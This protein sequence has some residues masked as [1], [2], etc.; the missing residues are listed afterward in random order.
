M[1]SGSYYCSL[2]EGPDVS[3]VPSAL[4]HLFPTSPDLD[5]KGRKYVFILE[6]K[7]AAARHL[8]KWK[9]LASG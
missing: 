5:S 6:E 2:G 1:G 4:T 8:E 9:W 7:S 3:G